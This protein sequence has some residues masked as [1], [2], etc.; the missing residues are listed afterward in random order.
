MV[1]TPR[2]GA[3]TGVSSLSAAMVLRGTGVGAM[4][5][6]VLAAVL[7]WESPHQAIRAVRSLQSSRGLSLDVV[8]VDNASDDQSYRFLTAKLEGITVIRSS[9]NRGYAGGMNIALNLAESKGSQFVLLVTQD[10][11]AAP[12]MVCSLL[13]A[14]ELEPLAAVAGPIVLSL[15]E[16][17]KVLSAGGYTDAAR[18]E[19]GHFRAPLKPEPYEVDWVDG[20][21]MMLRTEAIRDT[22]GFDELFFMYYEENDLCQR[23]RRQGWKVI[24]QPSAHA[25]HEAEPAPRSP[26][27]HY[28]MARNAYLFWCKNFGLSFWVVARKHM[29]S[30]AK[31]YAAA[32]GSLVVPET[33]VRLGVRTRFTSAFRA[34]KGFLLGSRDYLRHLKSSASLATRCAWNSGPD[35]QN[36]EVH[37]TS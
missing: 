17:D 18:V 22:G 28:Y 29:Y 25:W 2:S 31:Q 30:L 4:R 14:M 11:V 12:D 32:L 19:V 9:A 35:Q 27:Y 21:C 1:P 3:R 37:G 24:V 6:R 23:V 36:Y 33:R 20:C 10:V 15:Q 7:H 8:V 5:P 16:R 13:R 34:T 26:R